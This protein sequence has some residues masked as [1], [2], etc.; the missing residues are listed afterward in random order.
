MSLKFLLHFTT[1][2][3]YLTYFGMFFQCVNQW[4]IYVQLFED[5]KEIPKTNIVFSSPIFVEKEESN[6]ELELIYL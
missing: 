3:R 2:M 4:Y 1:S 6:L 5:I